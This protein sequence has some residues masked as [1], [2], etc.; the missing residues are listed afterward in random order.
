MPLCAQCFKNNVCGPHQDILL[1]RFS[2]QQFVPIR[3][4]KPVV[5]CR[6]NAGSCPDLNK[7]H[8]EVAKINLGRI[9]IKQNF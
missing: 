8:T 9:F 5:T 1:T 6:Q 7:K 2:C 4:I 3:R